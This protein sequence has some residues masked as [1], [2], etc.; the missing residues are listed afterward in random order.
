MT[1][2]LDKIL[3]AEDELKGRGPARPG[4]GR[5]ACSALLAA[6]D[7]RFLDHG[8]PALVVEPVEDSSRRPL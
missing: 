2:L 3:A 8:R 1:A 4:L 6:H 7:F 5:P